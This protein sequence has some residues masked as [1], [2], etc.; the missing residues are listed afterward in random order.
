MRPWS[1]NQ[2]INVIDLCCLQKEE[3]RGEKKETKKKTKKTKEKK[4]M[5]GTAERRDLLGWRSGG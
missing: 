4:K 2:R 3:G 1:C 5:V